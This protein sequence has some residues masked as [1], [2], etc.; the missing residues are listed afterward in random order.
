MCRD[1]GRDY[2][3]TN[4]PSV[5]LM[6]QTDSHLHPPRDITGRASA[7]DRLPPPTP[8]NGE[9]EEVRG[10]EPAQWK[11]SHHQPQQSPNSPEVVEETRYISHPLSSTQRG[12]GVST[13]HLHCH[14]PI[15][16]CKILWLPQLLYCRCCCFRRRRN[17]KSSWCS[18]NR[19]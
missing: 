2:T 17:R 4:L 12:G 7:N 5:S 14:S 16:Y 15:M 10:N 6:L 3:L 19:M 1:Y 9:L 13:W 18:V 8:G 11:P